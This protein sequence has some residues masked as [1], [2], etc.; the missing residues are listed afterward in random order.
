MPFS[1]VSACQCYWSFF[2]NFTPDGDVRLRILLGGGGFGVGVGGGSLPILPISQAGNL[3][4]TNPIYMQEYW[5]PQLQ[6]CNV[7]LKW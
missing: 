6:R 1:F 7:G 4:L 3:A 2:F 5:K